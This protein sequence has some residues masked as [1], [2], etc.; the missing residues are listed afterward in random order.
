MTRA[1]QIQCERLVA[2]H[3]SGER[4]GFGRFFREVSA[5]IGEFLL[6]FPSSGRA[7]PVRVQRHE[8]GLGDHE[9]GHPELAD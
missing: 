2:F 5:R 3:D 4:T 6:H 1:A 9:V 8:F 7:S